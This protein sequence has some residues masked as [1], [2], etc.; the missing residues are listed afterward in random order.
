MSQDMSTYVIY[1]SYIYISNITREMLHFIHSYFNV[2]G[3]ISPLS[4][5]V[6]CK[7]MMHQR[8]SK[9]TLW[10]DYVFNHCFKSQ[11]STSST[12][13]IR[14]TIIALVQCHEILLHD[15]LECSLRFTLI[16]K[17]HTPSPY[18]WC[19]SF[20]HSAWRTVLLRQRRAEKV[21]AITRKE[22]QERSTF[23]T[24]LL[25]FP[26]FCARNILPF[27]DTNPTWQLYLM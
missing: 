1:F 7:H 16:L 14:I 15:P 6:S 17:T 8:V 12:T 25:Q 3:I 13:I 18:F 11:E 27:S 2:N 19:T 5:L 21:S 9:L 24:S 26:K 4:I 20:T 23:F 10:W 22:W